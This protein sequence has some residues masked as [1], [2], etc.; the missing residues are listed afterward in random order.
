MSLIDNLNQAS[1]VSRLNAIDAAYAGSPYA[2]SNFK[3]RWQGYNEDGMAIVKYQGQ[4]YTAKNLS[5]KAATKNKTVIL[6]VA[7]GFRTTNH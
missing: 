4:V 2:G 3:A 5:P 1:G 7:K 6:R